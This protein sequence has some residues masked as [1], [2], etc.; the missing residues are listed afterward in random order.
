MKGIR[1]Q[2][3]ASFLITAVVVVILAMTMFVVIRG[4]EN[5]RSIDLWVQTGFNTL[6]QIVMIGTWLPEGKKRGQQ[7]ETYIANK[8][9]A[10]VEMQNAATPDNFPFLVVFCRKMTAENIAYW[11][12]KRAARL[13]V[14]Y[15]QWTASE[16]YRALFDTKTA[17]KIQRLERKA[18]RAVDEIKAT[19]IVTK[20]SISLVHDTKDHTTS[21]TTANVV[22]K[23]LLSVFLCTAGAFMQPEATAFTV[24]ALVDFLYWLLVMCL[25]IFYSL[26]TGYRLIA[27]E[28]NDYYKRIIVFLRNFEAWRQKEAENEAA[29]KNVNITQQ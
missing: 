17:Q 11:V 24:S 9:A 15:T 2:E 5:W 4:S 21:A 28:Q 1:L 10:N 25:S 16:A 20:S 26:R 12:Q 3:Y 7:N 19:E 27:V 22:I 29:E 18:A 14:V 23:I 6:L 8:T 13:G